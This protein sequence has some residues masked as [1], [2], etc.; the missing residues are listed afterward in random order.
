MATT[1]F[2]RRDLNRFR[3]VYPSVKYP[4]RLTGISSNSDLE[5][6][7][8]KMTFT[9]QSSKTY[10]FASTYTTVPTVVASAVDSLGNN[11]ANVNVFVS[12]ITLT[13][14]EISTSQVFSGEVHV[15]VISA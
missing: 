8:T 4:Q 10:T 14:V 3:K 13:N 6:E 15:Q 2:T 9:N 11:N 12:A 5:I 7:T 1:T